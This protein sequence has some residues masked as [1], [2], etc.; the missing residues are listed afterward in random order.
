MEQLLK[1]GQV[2][3]F[4]DKNGIFTLLMKGF[5]FNKNV[6]SVVDIATKLTDKKNI[7]VL[8]NE[9]DYILLILV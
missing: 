8:K 3:V 5:G 6:L 9:D 1:F 2:E 4:S 7:Q